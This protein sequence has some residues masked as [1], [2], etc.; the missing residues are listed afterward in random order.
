MCRCKSFH[1][2]KNLDTAKVF[3]WTFKRIFTDS[4]IPG[5]QDNSVYK[6]T[7]TKSQSSHYI[8]NLRGGSFETEEIPNDMLGRKRL[9]TKAGLSKIVQKD[10]E[11]S[12]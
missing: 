5:H 7:I 3:S 8:S 4:V 10:N 2:T 6:S 12:L 9:K 11:A 1:N